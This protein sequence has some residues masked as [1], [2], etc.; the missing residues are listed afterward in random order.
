MGHISI[1][2]TATTD[3]TMRRAAEL[4][5]QAQVEIYE[6][7]RRC[8]AQED[9]IRDLWGARIEKIAGKAGL[10]AYRNH[11]QARDMIWQGEAALRKW[12][13]DV[14]H[15]AWRDA[16][17]ELLDEGRAQLASSWQK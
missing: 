10:L 15:L 14:D 5:C 9:A 2:A 11:C 1:M 6:S 7:R 16:A 17:L 12:G 3:F 4:C 13:E 8:D